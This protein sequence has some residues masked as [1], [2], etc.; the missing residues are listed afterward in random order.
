MGGTEH[1]HNKSFFALTSDLY[2]ILFLCH[3]STPVDV[4]FK[5]FFATDLDRS[6]FMVS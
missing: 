1:R 4:V 5:H 2:G 3:C 6:R